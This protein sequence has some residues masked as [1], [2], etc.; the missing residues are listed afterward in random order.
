[1][2]QNTDFI[3]EGGALLQYTGDDACVSIPEYVTSIKGNAF[4]NNKKLTRVVI[5]DSVT[6]VGF[7]AFS[8]CTALND[9]VVGKGVTIFQQYVF[10]GCTSLKE[11]CIPGN[12]KT[13][14][15]GMFT[16]CFSLKDVHIEEGV[17]K[18]SSAAFSGCR[19]LEELVIPSTVGS[20]GRYAFSKCHNLRRVTIE[21]ETVNI[22]NLAFYKCP[23]DLAIEWKSKTSFS[24]E[25]GQ[26]FDITP[27]GVLRAYFGTKKDV[28]VP[29]CVTSMG[30][31]CFFERTDIISVSLPDTIHTIGEHAFAHTSALE[32]VDM[33]RVETIEGGAFWASGIVEAY[34]PETLTE[35]GKDLFGSC[36]NLTK[37][38]F[39][40]EHVSFKGRIA[41]MCYN[42]E[43]VVL[44]SRQKYIPSMAFYYCEHLKRMVI[45][46]TV[47]YFGDQV[48]LGCHD[49]KNNYT[50]VTTTEEKEK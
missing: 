48:F 34:F 20:I 5:P 6:Q 44:P 47:K 29:T 24:G 12:V 9:V 11:I 50:L 45:P 13:L 30:R 1:M 35:A 33:P 49:Y 18:V 4:S 39:A 15:Y 7:A 38:T 27:N 22:S 2:E 37:I 14:N 25:A 16:D 40:S 41:P 28:V 8:N 10:S 23:E 26:G 31:C 3:C 21:S 46:N 19:A 43:E 32:H 42:L 17:R 36:N